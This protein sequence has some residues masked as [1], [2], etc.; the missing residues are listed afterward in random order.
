L[1]RRYS[2]ILLDTD[3][4]HSSLQ[5]REISGR[6]DL[7]K[8]VDAID[9]VEGMVHQHR[10]DYD[11]VVIDCPPS[12]HSDETWQALSSSDMVLLP[13][14]PSP[15]DLWATVHVE[16]ELESARSVNPDIRA[17]MVINQLEPRT[18]LS[19]LMRD[20]LAEIDIPVAE[21]EIRRRV[22]YRNAMLRGLSVLDT[23]A[24]AAD[25]AEEIEQLAKE[26]VRLS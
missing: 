3:P 14:L 9:D 10:K 11:C 18:R 17:L 15:L 16:E 5:W 26:V 25:A 6:D 24:S 23:G 4:Q 20:A 21:T 22:A 19:R 1:Q 13:I 8:V 2:T 12:V 7:V